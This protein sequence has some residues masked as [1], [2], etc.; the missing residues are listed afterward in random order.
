MMGFMSFVLKHFA[1]ISYW[2]DLPLLN[3]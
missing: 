3:H 2:Y 1:N